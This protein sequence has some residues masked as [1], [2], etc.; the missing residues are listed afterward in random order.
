M[1]VFF[2]LSTF[3]N[4][5]KF[6]CQKSFIQRKCSVW[7]SNCLPC[8]SQTFCNLSILCNFFFDEYYHFY[9]FINLCYF[10][11]K[12]FFL[13]FFNIFKTYCV[14]CEL[15]LFLTLELLSSG[16]VG[17]VL[18]WKHMENDFLSSSKA[19]NSK[20]DVSREEDVVTTCKGPR[21]RR[22]VPAFVQNLL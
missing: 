17:D 2:T 8:I 11:N 5:A 15:M 7:K 6:P 4:L 22:R 12:I 3:E 14:L 18:K 19:E 9:H 20:R 10:T 1:P 16:D 13:T 21:W